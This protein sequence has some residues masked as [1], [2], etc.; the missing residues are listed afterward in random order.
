MRG[1]SAAVR[2]DTVELICTGIP[3][4]RAASMARIVRSNEPGTR[5]NSSCAAAS[6]WS[7]EIAR[8]VTPC[9]FIVAIAW[10]VSSV[11]ALQRIA[12]GDHEDLRLQAGDVVDQREA[13]RR[14]QLELRAARLR[15][16]AAMHA[17]EVARPGHL[18]DRHE[19]VLIEVD[20]HEIS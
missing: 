6:Q 10:G 12:A 18:P 13:L 8:R 9:A 14:R 3:L 19:G 4:S 15:G 16:G 11:V 20:V 5:R 7:S 17:S 2:F 1:M